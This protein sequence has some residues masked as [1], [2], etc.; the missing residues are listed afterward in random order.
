MST[1]YG[2]LK[3]L[4]PVGPTGAALLDYAIYDAFLAGFD[5]VAVVVR[6]EIAAAVREHVLTRW[7]DLPVAFPEQ[8]QDRMPPGRTKPW[9]T[10][11]AALCAA[12][13][14]DGPFAVAN[15]DD[16]YGRQ[17]YALLADHLRSRPAE[18]ALVS[19][20]LDATLSP[21][22]GVSRGICAL[23][24]DMVTGIEEYVGVEQQGSRIVGR[25]PR[26]DVHVLAPDTPTSMNLWGLTAAVP[27]LLAEGFTAFADDRARAAEQE[28]LLSS[29]LGGL[30]ADGRIRL[31]AAGPVGG[32]MGMTFPDDRARVAAALRAATDA[33]TYPA[34]L[35]PTGRD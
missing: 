25:D 14:L 13:V 33:G 22:G 7:A 27:A 9:G 17:A 18:Q 24:G 5:R 16:F 19:Y 29:E 32:W 12:P 6:R 2:R 21:S 4:E 10:A 30:A 31:R 15:A 23:D 26:G 20:R 8:D 3:Q 28:F 34:D 35:G 1:R 11:H